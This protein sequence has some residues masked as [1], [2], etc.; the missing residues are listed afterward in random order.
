MRSLV[1]RSFSPSPVSHLELVLDATFSYPDFCLS[2]LGKGRPPLFFVLFKIWP[3][4]SFTAISTAHLSKI[5]FPPPPFCFDFNILKSG[6]QGWPSADRNNKATLLLTGPFRSAKSSARDLDPRRWNYNPRSARW[7]FSPAVKSPAEVLT[8]AY[9]YRLCRGGVAASGTDSDLE[10]FSHY[11]ADGSF[12]ALPFPT[13][14]LPIIW[15]SG[16]SRTKLNYHCDEF[17]SRVKLTCLT[18]V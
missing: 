7:S 17:I 3:R 10:A 13:A 14:T 2:K 1:R 4:R 5:L 9:S 6:E 15:I 11:P 8:R 18:T 12:A 16:S